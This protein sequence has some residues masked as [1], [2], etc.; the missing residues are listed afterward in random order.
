MCT[1]PVMT[2]F[3]DGTWTV[4]NTLPSG[5]SSMPLFAE[6]RCFSR[7]S[8]SGSLRISVN[9]TSRCAPLSWLVTTMTARRAV[10]SSFSALRMSRCKGLLHLLDEH[11]DL[12]AAGQP[13]LPGSLVGDAE[14]ERLGLA[15]FDHVDGLGDHR[16]FD[17]AARHRAQE[18]ALL[19]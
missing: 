5:V 6:R 17:A 9:F 10:R 18:V 11:L 3:G 13:D 19:V 7:K 8:F 15:A 4:R 2:S 14:F 12:A 1:A 16:A